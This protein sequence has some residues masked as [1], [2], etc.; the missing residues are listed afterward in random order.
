M[1]FDAIVNKLKAK[2]PDVE[3]P[4]V[5]A[6]DRIVILPTKDSFEILKFLK[7][8]PELYF[9]SL[10]SLAGA[11]SG[12]E[13]W[14][15]YPLHSFKHL[16][17]LYVKVVLPRENPECD[18]VVSLWMVANFFEREAYD[19]YGIVFK[20]HPDLRRIIN[21]PDWIGWAG[22]K[23]YEYPADYHGIPTVRADQFFADEVE[24]GIAER[25]LQE[26]QLL[27]K[28]GLTEKK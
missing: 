25:E 1:E 9:D 14:V 15:I 23:D 8:D 13:L 6:G 18:S 5:E 7:E 22:R 20:N 11:D 16:H 4:K 26:K 17:K 27:E 28:L 2:W 21:P 24:R 3:A 10:M 19:L 12:R